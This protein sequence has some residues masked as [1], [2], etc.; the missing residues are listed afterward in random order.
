M[1]KAIIN[2]H[3]GLTYTHGFKQPIMN[4]SHQ[5][6]YMKSY[7]SIFSLRFNIFHRRFWVGA[8]VKLHCGW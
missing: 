7:N 4:D 2:I 5:I 1:F 3:L 6:T 8:Y